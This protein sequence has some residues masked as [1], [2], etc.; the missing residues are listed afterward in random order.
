MPKR[1]DHAQRRAHIADALVRVAARDGLHAVTMRAV[2]AEAGMSLNLVQYYFDTKAQLMHA[3]LQHLE[4][5]SHERWSAR[6]ESLENPGSARACLEAFVDEALPVDADSHTFRLVWTSYAVL[7][8]TDPELAEQP[9]VEGP[10]RLERQLTHIL[11]TARAAGEIAAYLDV[12]A[13]A[14][15]LLSLSHGVGTSVLVGQRSAA[16][17]RYVMLY[18]LSRLFNDPTPPETPGQHLMAVS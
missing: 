7:A 15:L 14:S 17:A 5:Q 11:A 10:N 9:F 2:A 4:Q 12:S 6:L 8:M 1:V 13:E 3:A 18:H 16:Q